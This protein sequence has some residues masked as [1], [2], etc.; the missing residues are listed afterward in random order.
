[1]NRDIPQDVPEGDLEEGAVGGQPV[2][3]YARSRAD[4]SEYLH[5]LVSYIYIVLF[6]DLIQTEILF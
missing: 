1:M 2:Y 4:L 3:C 6:L 5:R